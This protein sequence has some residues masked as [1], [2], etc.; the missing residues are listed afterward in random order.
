MMSKIVWIGH[1]IDES[2]VFHFNNFTVTSRCARELYR[3]INSHF[4]PYIFTSFEKMDKKI[5]FYGIVCP[6]MPGAVASLGKDGQLGI[7]KKALRICNDLGADQICIA[8]LFASIWEDASELKA[9]TRSSITTGKNLIAAL[10]IDYIARAIDMLKGNPADSVLGII[11]SNNRISKTFITHYDDKVRSIL[12]DQDCAE[13]SGRNITRKASYEDI[14]KMSDV[15]I[16][17]TMGVGLAPY[18]GM[19]KPG[20][21]VC[22]IVVPYY[23]TKDICK[24]RNDVFAFEGVWSRYEHINEYEGSD[25]KRLFPGDVMPACVAEP[26]ILVLED[27]VCDFSLSNGINYQNMMQMNEMRLRCGFQHFGFKQGPRLY[28]NDA[29]ET[30][31]KSIKKETIYA[32]KR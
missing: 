10:V 7:M 26:L 16:V 4:L 30:I 17:T 28:S 18:I 27:R 29:I 32:T 21:I 23:L 24:T 3:K 31:R 9:F 11:G 2:D 12:T 15:I 8:A 25:L 19:I 20:A 1:Y 5:E 22:D 13:A 6:L 14:F